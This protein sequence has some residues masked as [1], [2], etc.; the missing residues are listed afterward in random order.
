MGR[1]ECLMKEQVKRWT[2]LYEATAND[3]AQPARL[4]LIIPVTFTEC[5][6]GAFS[7]VRRY[8][9]PPLKKI[10]TAAE[11]VAL[12]QQCCDS[13][14]ASSQYKGRSPSPTFSLWLISVALECILKLLIRLKMRAHA[15]PRLS[16]RTWNVFTQFALRQQAAWVRLINAF[17]LIAVCRAA[18]SQILELMTVTY[19]SVVI[20]SHAW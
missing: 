9:L 2:A 20:W 6:F 3:D 19:R 4:I 1:P 5:S 14:T 17:A 7:R 18:I 11:C 10:W 16:S 12:K 8:F 15:L 13:S